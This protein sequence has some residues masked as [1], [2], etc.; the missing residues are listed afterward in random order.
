[1]HLEEPP[2]IGKCQGLTLYRNVSSCHFACKTK[3]VMVYIV[4]IRSGLQ[5]SYSHLGH[6]L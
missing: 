1:M 6:N 2:L 4:N 5:L 3:E